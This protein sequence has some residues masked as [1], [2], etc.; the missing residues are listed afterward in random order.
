[1]LCRQDS[2]QSAQKQLQASLQ[3]LTAQLQAE[4]K[5]H[6][7]S[8]GALLRSIPVLGAHAHL[9]WMLASCGLHLL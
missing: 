9:Y 8:S 6:R 2:H 7:V 5:A 1:M 4:Q 3:E